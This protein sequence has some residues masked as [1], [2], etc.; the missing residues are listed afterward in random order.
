[1]EGDAREPGF[2]VVIGDE[3]RTV[4]YAERLRDGRIAL[5]TR[6]QRRN[7]EWEPGEMQLLEPTAGLDLAA[8]LSDMV[9]ESWMAAVRERQP[10]PL[11]TA[12]E[13]Y[14]PGAGGVRRLAEEMLREIPPELMVRAMVLLANSVGPDTRK[15]LVQRLNRTEAGWEEAALRR[16]MADEH[17]AFAYSVA[18]AALF[19]ALATGV[20]DEDEEG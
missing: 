11:R 3:P 18:A 10:E 1:V 4:L 9:E 20:A 13:L 2:E 6:S 15:R 8:W 14:G 19:D 12:E 17:E 7:G 5:G 16:R